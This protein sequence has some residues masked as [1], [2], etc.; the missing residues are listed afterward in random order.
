MLTFADFTSQVGTLLEVDIPEDISP[1]DSLYE[2]LG[3]DSF[4]A[5]ELICIVEGMADC[6]VPP[7]TLPEMYTL[8]DA[9]GYYEELKASSHAVDTEP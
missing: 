7:E 9:F 4:Q 3:L 5:Y 6:L 2:E 1:Y 8:S